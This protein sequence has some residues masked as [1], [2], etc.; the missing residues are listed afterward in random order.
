[1]IYYFLIFKQAYDLLF[2]ITEK[3]QLGFV[4]IYYFLSEQR[5]KKSWVRKKTCFN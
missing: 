4:M 5:S 3:T 1:M 2:M